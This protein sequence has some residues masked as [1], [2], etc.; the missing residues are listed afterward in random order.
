MKPDRIETL[1]LPNGD[2]EEVLIVSDTPTEIVVQVLETGQVLT[3][4]KFAQ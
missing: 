3:Y 1:I 2:K 4:Q